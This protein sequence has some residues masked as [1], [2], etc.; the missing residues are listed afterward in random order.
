MCYLE[1]IVDL[2][3]CDISLD[4]KSSEISAETGKGCG[5]LLSSFSSALDFFYWLSS[6]V[7][8]LLPRFDS[9]TCPLAKSSPGL[10]WLAEDLLYAAILAASVGRLLLVG[11]T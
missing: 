3:C 11:P 9:R 7:L 6:V 4:E 8:V 1:G 10:G 2:R 5:G